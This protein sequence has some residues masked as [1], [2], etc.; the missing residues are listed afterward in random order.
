MDLFRTRRTTSASDRRR[1]AATDVLVVLVVVAVIVPMSRRSPEVR[2]HVAATAAA[3]TTHAN[4][5]EP[6]RVYL[7]H[8]HNTRAAATTATPAEEAAVGS[9]ARPESARPAQHP[10]TAT[11]TAADT[12]PWRASDAAGTSPADPDSARSW[13]IE[14]A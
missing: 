7:L 6:M 1:D 8:S 12:H 4:R 3:A 5:I 13:K 2:L 14:D 11:A 10:W 9:A